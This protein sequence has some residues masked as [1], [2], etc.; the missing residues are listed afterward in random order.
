MRLFSYF[1]D[2]ETDS[3]LQS[4]LSQAPGYLRMERGFPD[5]QPPCHPHDALDNRIHDGSR[6]H[7]RSPQ[8]PRI[9]QL[10]FLKITVGINFM[11]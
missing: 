7:T 10:N 11:C 2:E 5:L 3:G 9:L 1:T 6:V 4:N 8:T